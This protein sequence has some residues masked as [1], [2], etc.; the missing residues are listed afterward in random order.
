MGDHE[1]GKVWSGYT[2]VLF[3]IERVKVSQTRKKD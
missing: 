3:K 2:L 1:R